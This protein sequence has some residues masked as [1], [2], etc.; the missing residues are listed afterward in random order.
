MLVKYINGRIADRGYVTT[1]VI[2][3]EQDLRSGTLCLRLI[4]GRI[5]SIRFA[6]P[7]LYG[8]WHNAFPISAG[9]ILNVR[10]L[11]QGLEQMQQAGNQKVQLQLLPGKSSGASDVIL[12][13][14]RSKPWAVFLQLDD[15]GLTDTGRREG[16]AGF[17]LYNPTGL[18][19]RFSYTYSRD[20][21]G[22]AAFGTKGYSF[23]YVLPLGRWTFDV[24][25]YHNEYK[26]QVA[27]LVPYNLR[28]ASDM[29]EVGLTGVLYRNQ[30]CKTQ[31]FLKLLKKDRR[32]WMHGDEIGVQRQDTAAWRA[33]VMHRQY[34]GD[35][36]LDANLY[37]QQGMPWMGAEAGTDD[38]S[39]DYPTTRYGLWGASLYMATPVALGHVKGQYTLIARG[40]YTQNKLYATEQFSIGGRYTV[41]GFDGEQTLA[42]DNGYIIRNE[43]SIPLGKEAL[44][45]YLGV[46]YG[47]VWGFGSEYLTGKELVGSVM[48]LRGTISDWQYDVFIG[49]PLYKPSGFKTAKAALGCTLTCSF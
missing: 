46:D 11:E 35:L 30:T 26:E 25:V 2:L 3:P 29:V 4:P 12:S 47:R 48:G 41:R 28:S 38:F 36:V 13:V 5:G 23:S 7:R 37:Y 19:D 34:F 32:T 17:V 42:A 39:G 16:S 10:D 1:M 33:G 14:E 27:A 49:A 22:H 31:G 15:A 21:E 45:F 18:N 24:N 8:T 44:A 20:I 9:D 43:L 40:Q 6:E